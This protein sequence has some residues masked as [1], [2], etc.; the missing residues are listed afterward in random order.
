MPILLKYRTIIVCLLAGMLYALGFPL[1]NGSSLFIA[2]IIGFAL[3]NWALDQETSLKKQFVL[4]LAYSLG[5][6][7]LGF[8]WIPHTLKE[9]GGLFFPLNH[10]LGLV[11][12]FVII[13]QVYCYVVL[14]NK[15]KHPLFLAV[16]YVL[17]ERFVPQQLSLIHI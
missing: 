17:L 2:P 14:K 7:L 12:S 1:F 15:I 9:F 16:G 4:S 5:F 3:F 13:P 10:L 11:F 6:Y 8:Y